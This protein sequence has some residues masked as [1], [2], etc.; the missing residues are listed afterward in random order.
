MLRTPCLDCGADSS[1]AR[2]QRHCEACLNEPFPPAGAPQPRVL[3][4]LGGTSLRGA[5][6]SHDIAHKNHKSVRTWQQ[7]DHERTLV[8]SMS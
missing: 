1:T 6:L 2:G 7:I 4:A 3:G 5:A 8:S